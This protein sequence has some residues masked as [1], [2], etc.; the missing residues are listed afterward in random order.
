MCATPLQPNRRD[1][2][3]KVSVHRCRAQSLP[4]VNIARMAMRAIF[5]IGP[6]DNDGVGAWVRPMDGGEAIY[7]KWY[8][9]T[10]DALIDANEMGPGSLER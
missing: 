5:T 3:G 4:A 2:W 10:H 7:W 6:I 8:Q 1:P 9:T